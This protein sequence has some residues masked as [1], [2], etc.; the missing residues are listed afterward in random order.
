MDIGYI[1]LILACITV[2]TDFVLIAVNYGKF[3]HGKFRPLHLTFFLSIALLLCAYFRILVAFLT[4]DFA[5]K[6]VFLYSSSGL[7]LMF[8]IANT[9]IGESSSLL[10][11]CL[12]F[13][14]SYL[15]LRLSASSS[16]SVRRAQF[17]SM[18]FLIADVF[19]LFLIIIVIVE[20]PFESIQP[21]SIQPPV[22]G[23]GLNPLL[24]NV[25]VLIHPPVLFIGYSLTM[26]SFSIALARMITSA[27]TASPSGTASLSSEC[28]DDADANYAGAA[29]ANYAGA[30]DDVR[31]ERNERNERN[32]SDLSS[33]RNKERRE[34]RPYEEFTVLLAW[35]FLSLGISLGGLW[36]YEVLGWGGYW[37]WDP[38]ET[39]SLLPWLA[40]TAYFHLSA[41]RDD[42]AREFMLF[43]AFFM[44]IFA[45]ALTRGG[46]LESVHAFARSPL[47]YVILIFGAVMGILFFVLRIILRKPI[48]MFDV[49]VRSLQSLSRFIVFWS[50][51][52]ALIVCVA[53][54]LMPIAGSMLTGVEM[55]TQQEFFTKWC[56]PPTI[57]FVIALAGC[58]LR[59]SVKRFLL[60]TA[61]VSALGA[62][63]AFLKMPL[64][65]TLANFG[66][67]FLCFAAL[68]II[69]NFTRIIGKARA[70][71]TILIHLAIVII[72]LGVFV[73]SS[74][75][76]DSGDIKVALGDEVNVFN[77]KIR[78]GDECQLFKST[79][80]VYRAHILPEYTMLR[81]G[82]SI[83]TSYHTY[84]DTLWMRYYPNYELLTRP[85]I[86]SEPARDIYVSMKYTDTLYD[87]LRNAMMFGEASP[88]SHIVI[89]VKVVPLVSLIW[90]GVIMMS[91]G[92]IIVV[93]S[94]T[95]SKSDSKKS[96]SKS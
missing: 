20:N 18:L 35:L 28:C 19:L 23:M 51:L 84:K 76:Q 7:P 75:E 82:I 72:L 62:A 24:Q 8:K 91:A 85:L 90:V 25:W 38:V 10:F 33:L 54:E 27:A 15:F 73:S 26:F 78:I 4:D 2:V 44:V 36:S 29:G 80:T 60:L 22:E 81:T 83:N 31:N 87:T 12:V 17:S 65:N 89:N 1:F 57:A 49:D 11:M 32:L 52:L 53:G 42:I 68:A 64:P 34:E 74:A 6:E 94:R 88:P 37:A 30:I 70:L 56:Y 46:L 43:I 58:N 66:I 95:S 86:I 5:L 41:K 14:L 3:R 79:G 9:W 16:P 77:A 69:S 67:P 63:L 48:Y 55:K 92:M 47:G 13:A 59:M 21:E 96:D 71:G 45:S 61:F 93:L 50:L 40:L 39:A